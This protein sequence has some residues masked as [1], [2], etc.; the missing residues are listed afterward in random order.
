MIERG[1]ESGSLDESVIR[2]Q[3]AIPVPIY[4]PVTPTSRYLT[5]QYL[6]ISTTALDVRHCGP[7]QVEYP[8]Y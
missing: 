3:A 4:S 6:G 8:S 5:I 7:Q 2:H 1:K